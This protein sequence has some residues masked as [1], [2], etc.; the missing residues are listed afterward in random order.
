MSDFDQGN[1]TLRSG[2]DYP[3]AIGTIKAADNGDM[4]FAPKAEL[5]TLRK[6]A[7]TLLEKDY[8]VEEI[9]RLLLAVGN[10]VYTLTTARVCKRL[11]E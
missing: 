8:P 3:N 5:D 9:P 4:L 2:K 6:A 11:M 7:Q 10:E 1:D